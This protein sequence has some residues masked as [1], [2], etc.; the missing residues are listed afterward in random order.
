MVQKFHHYLLANP[1]V[2]YVDHQALKYLIVKPCLTRRITQWLL[3][4]QEFQFWIVLKAGKSHLPA[5]HMLHISNNMFDSSVDDEFPDAMLFV[6]DVVPEWYFGVSEYL[7]T[8][9]MPI[10]LSKVQ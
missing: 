7:S 6:V 1:F 2:F 4:L 10:D 3:L 5:D 8:S 9:K